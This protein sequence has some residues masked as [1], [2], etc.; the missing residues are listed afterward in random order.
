MH[1]S[2]PCVESCLVFIK[3]HRSCKNYKTTDIWNNERSK[4]K[5]NQPNKPQ[6]ILL[7]LLITRN[8]ENV[9]KFIYLIKTLIINE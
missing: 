8:I 6:S 4:T 5:I 7:I 2:F 3:N 9:V 1:F